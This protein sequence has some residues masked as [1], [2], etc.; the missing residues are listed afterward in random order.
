MSWVGGGP[1][2]RS[3]SPLPSCES[4]FEATKILNRTRISHAVA[5]RVPFFAMTMSLSSHWVAEGSRSSL[6]I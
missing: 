1:K 2:R 3:S 6:W 5:L 4:C